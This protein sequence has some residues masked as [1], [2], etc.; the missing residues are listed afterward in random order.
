MCPS[1]EANLWAIQKIKAIDC[2]AVPK[3]LR[4]SVAFNNPAPDTLDFFEDVEFKN[5]TIDTS[6]WR[7]YNKKKIQGNTTVVFIDID[8]KSFDDLKAIGFRPYYANGR[9]KITIDSTNQND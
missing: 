9:T 6:E 4:A 3:M 5:D 1:E 8:E 7:V 2:G